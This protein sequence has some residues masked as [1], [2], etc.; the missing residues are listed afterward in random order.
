M[1]YRGTF[2]MFV[3]IGSIALNSVAVAAPPATFDVTAEQVARLGVALS[4][5]ER[6]DSIEVASA[7]AE[8]VVP[9]A[10]RALVS[11]PLAGV[12]V[13]L[14][15]AEGD[16]VAAGQP[17][18]ELQSAEFLD[19]QREYLD[20]VAAAELAGAQESRDRGLFEEG[21]IAERRRDE[22]VAAARAARVQRDMTR[23]QL[24]LAGLSSADLVR[25]DTGRELATR[26]VLRAP[27]AGVVAAVHA[28]IGARLDALDA[29]LE[30][31]D[32]STL[33]LELRLRQESSAGVAVGM[34]VVAAA[35]D[36]T[37]RGTVTTVGRVVD[38]Q[39]Q[40]VLVRATLE[41]VSVPLRAGQFLTARVLA[42]PSSGAA[43]S[44][45]V[46]ALSRSGG[47]QVVFVRNGATFTAQPVAVLAEGG[48]RAYVAE[49]IDGEVAVEGI[50]ALKSLWLASEEGS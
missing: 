35:G 11:A 34:G 5:A 31:A 45:P 44:V 10:Q 12:I 25:L 7:P 17:L 48:A 36:A 33:W 46:A 23:A 15:V 50:S 27:L 18:A 41:G 1:N 4:A 8:V 6:V 38:P 39:S 20:A 49:R 16:T 43:Y 3:A 26:I 37:V 22:S 28:E 29:V 9:A 21:I 42:R 40:T 32:L 19:R 47:E 13:R 2:A 14:L 30:V 24:Q